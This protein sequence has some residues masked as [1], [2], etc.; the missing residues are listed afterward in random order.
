MAAQKSSRLGFCP[1]CNEEIL[2]RH[3]LIRYETG[4]GEQE[5]WTECPNCSEVV[6][7]Q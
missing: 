5:A 7:P 3:T 6:H 2:P 1:L 4:E